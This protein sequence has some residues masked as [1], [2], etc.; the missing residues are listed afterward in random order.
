M[1]PPDLPFHCDLLC[2]FEII[3][4]NCFPSA[5]IKTF[6]SSTGDDYFYVGLLP[7]SLFVNMGKEDSSAPRRKPVT[8]AKKYI[9]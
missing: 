1:D 5:D 3:D 4:G 8:R 2:S 9:Q 7:V 6:I